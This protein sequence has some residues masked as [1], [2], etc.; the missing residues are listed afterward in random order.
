MTSENKQ[1]N[2]AESWLCVAAEAWSHCFCLCSLN[3]KFKGLCPNYGLDFNFPLTKYGEI[4]NN[5][6][7]LRGCLI[8]NFWKWR[9]IVPGT[10]FQN[11]MLPFLIYGLGAV[12]GSGWDRVQSPNQVGLHQEGRPVLKLSKGTSAVVTPGQKVFFTTVPELFSTWQQSLLR[13]IWNKHLYYNYSEVN[14]G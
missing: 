12:E 10:R 14:S 2:I 9:H 5:K 4:T 3:G 8:L 6:T 1:L 11:C 13:N 7:L